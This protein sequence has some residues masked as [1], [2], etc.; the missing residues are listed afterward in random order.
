MPM[1]GGMRPVSRFRHADG[2][3][4]VEVMVTAVIL[5]F[6]LLSILTL[7]DRAN[8]TTTTTVGREA[9]TN[10][11]REVVERAHA[12][13]YDDLT[14]GLAPQALRAAVDPAG[15]RESVATTATRWTIPSGRSATGRGSP[16]RIDLQVTACSVLAPSDRPR[17][18]D[19]TL[20]LCRS[21]EDGSGGGTTTTASS[22]SCSIRATDDPTIGVTL[23]LLVSVDLCV[24]GA[25]A[26]AVCTLLGP[27]APLEAVLDPLVGEDG[28]V[29]VLLGGLGG[30]FAAD[31]CGGRPVVPVSGGTA[32]ADSAR[33]VT[34]TASWGPR[35]TQSITLTTIVPRP[36]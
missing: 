1:T 23:E 14:P 15:A 20:T 18:I 5:A 9:A 8:G 10:I 24:G 13:D 31:L 2:F 34:V 12:V 36:S 26:G 22:G 19:P 17:V 27:T 3:T 6:G 29:N 11:A 25:L 16:P 21:T 4:L 33:R 35:D 30:S 28:A 32:P 7:V